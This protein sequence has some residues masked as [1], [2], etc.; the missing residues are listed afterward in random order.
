MRIDAEKPIPK[1][2]QL[3]EIIKHYFRN[4]HYEAGQK[5]PSENELINQFKVSRNT[6]RQALAELANEGFIYKRAGSG[7]FFSGKTQDAQTESS[8]LIGVITPMVSYYI[9]PKIIEGIDDI[10]S[11][12]RYNIVLGN[13]KGLLEKELVC[14]EQILEKGFGE[15]S[16]SV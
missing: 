11:K 16:V 10:A 4:E 8:C 15:P 9:Y 7:S 3:K 1:Y 2:L 12:K 14:L 13:S 6:V 5:I